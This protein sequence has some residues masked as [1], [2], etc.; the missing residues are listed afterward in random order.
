MSRVFVTG[1]TGL[2]GQNVVRDLLEKGFHVIGLLR[3]NPDLY[4]V[5]HSHLT[6]VKGGLFDDLSK[7]FQGIDYLFHIAAN[8]SQNGLNYS[9]YD[10]INNKASVQLVHTAIQASVKRVIY[11]ST[12]NTLGYGNIYDLGNERKKIKSPFSH[13]YYAKSKL[14]AETELLKLKDKIDIVILN[15]TFMLGA[16]DSKPSSGKLIQMVWNKKIAFYPP[17]GKNMVHVCDVSKAMINSITQGKNGE[18]YLISNTNLSYK[19]FYKKVNEIT[20]QKTRL[21]PISKRLLKSLGL[22]GNLLR[23]LKIKTNLNSTNMNILCVHN[24]YDNQKSKTELGIDYQTLDK[25]I[26]DAINYFKSQNV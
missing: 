18:K 2:L 14:L 17:G 23:F 16:F 7:P 22:I 10:N 19:M 8:T 21:I 4:P 13:S 12:A 11:V 5:K 9:D 3:S 6:L 26:N 1:I 15:P 24:Y 20:N 25:A